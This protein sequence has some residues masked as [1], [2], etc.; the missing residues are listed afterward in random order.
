MVL[1]ILFVG[2]SREEKCKDNISNNESG[3]SGAVNNDND[4]SRSFA[5]PKKQTSNLQKG[6]LLLLRCM[7]L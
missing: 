4:S 7:P 5:S 6:M 2:D 1:Q 3:S